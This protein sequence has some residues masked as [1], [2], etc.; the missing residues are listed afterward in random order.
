MNHLTNEADASRTRHRVG[1]V[2]VLFCGVAAAYFFAKGAMVAS[3]QSEPP[4]ALVT[5]ASAPQAG[6]WR[7]KPIEQVRQGEWVW[8]YDPTNG[9][10]RTREVIKP[11]EHD[12]AG[13]LITL[14]VGGTTIEATGNHPFWVASGSNL[15]SRHVVRDVSDA[16]REVSSAEG[17][18]W[19]EARS[20]QPGDLLIV[21]NGQTATV[22]EIAARRAEMKVY[23]LEVADLHTYAVGEL[24]VVVHNKS[25]VKVAVDGPGLIN[26][27]AESA[28]PRSTSLTVLTPEFTPNGTR[29]LQNLTN[30]VNQRLASNLP[31]ATT[32][33][34][35]EE[36]LA[37]TEYPG[38]ARSAYGNAVERLVAREIEADPVLDSLY[39]HVGGPNNPDFV[40]QGLFK[41]MNF[42]ITTSAQS[43]VHI[44]RPGYGRGLNIVTYERPPG[45]P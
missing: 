33:L 7:L 37:A 44:A 12:F 19:V 29:V 16:D 6:A 20:L 39:K 23:N 8:A 26:L 4:S 35:P 45:F 43:A 2:W 25:P 15:A 31:L 40:G 5:G 1:L 30:R 10:W 32:V 28:A 3:D 38:L 36:L 13:D 34:S 11:L 41:G 14:R 18:R 22:E 24:G 9:Q 27:A 21:R 17:G 42:D